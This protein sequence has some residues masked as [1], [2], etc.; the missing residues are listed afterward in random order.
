[1]HVKKNKTIAQD[2]F[3]NLITRTYLSGSRNHKTVKYAAHQK[4]IVFTCCVH[5]D[6]KC[7]QRLSMVVTFGHDVMFIKREIFRQANILSFYLFLLSQ[8]SKCVQ[9][10][11]KPPKNAAVTKTQTWKMQTGE[12]QSQRVSRENVTRGGSL[13][14]KLNF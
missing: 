6:G 10:S 8:H 13:S 5:L 12:C 7:Y 4:N 11:Q 2:T 9:R 14:L 1:M 3:Q